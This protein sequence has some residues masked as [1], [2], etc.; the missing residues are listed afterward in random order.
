L[1]NIFDQYS[2]PEN[3]LTHALATVLHQDRAVLRSFVRTFGPRDHPKASALKIIEQSLPGRPEPGEPLSRGLPDALLYSEEGWALAIESKISDTLSASQLR[4]HS[5][6]VERCGFDNVAGIAITVR[7]PRFTDQGWRMISWKDV[8]CWA[9]AQKSGSQWA[10]MLVDYFN[11]AEARMANDGYLKEGTITEFSGIAFDPYTYLEGKRILRLLRQKLRD[12]E[13]F[14]AEMRLAAGPG[15]SAI[16]DQE[17]LWDFISFIPA[18]HSDPA[19]QEFP[20][21]TV[22]IGPV[23][24]EAMITFPHRMPPALRKLL[25]GESFDEFTTR[26]ETASTALGRALKGLKAYRPMIRVM[27]R[28]YKTQRSTPMMDGRIE[29]DL[30]ATF[31]DD[32]PHFGPPIRRQ[33]QWARA[34]YELLANKRSNIQFQIGVEFYYPRLDELAHKDAD[35]YF[36]AAFK[37]LRPFA[38]PVIDA[39]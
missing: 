28:R 21:C 32:N 19:F 26:L 38:A 7:P 15:R 29:F 39:S 9:Q 33:P 30:R 1:R 6:T 18:D 17:R 11:I 24:A 5:R 10:A 27:Q 14:I 31:G 13:P 35:R 34:A 2:H 36:V 23:D 25:H 16:T 3:R 4:R 22:G 12:N 20:H 8:Y 37:A